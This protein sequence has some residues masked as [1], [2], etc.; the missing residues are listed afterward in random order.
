MSYY[1]TGTIALED[2]STSEF[3]ISSEHGYQQ[4]AAD[5]TRLGR[6]VDILAAMTD[7]IRNA[8]LDGDEPEDA[9]PPDDYDFYSYG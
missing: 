5:T 2:G 1:I 4:W 9:E 7:G 3:S 6:S 8:E